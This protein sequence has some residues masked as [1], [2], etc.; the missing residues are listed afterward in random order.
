MDI[1]WRF[2]PY[3]PI[4]NSNGQAMTN[5]PPTI[6]IVGAGFAWRSFGGQKS[7]IYEHLTEKNQDSPPHDQS[8]YQAEQQAGQQ[9]GAGR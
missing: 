8:F 3:L 6:V 9:S 2:F 7:L 1:S 4:S 5:T